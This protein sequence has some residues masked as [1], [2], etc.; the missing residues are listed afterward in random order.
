MRNEA[1]SKQPVYSQLAP[2]RSY[3]PSF[4]ILHQLFKHLAQQASNCMAGE[5]APQ[6]CLQKKN[7]AFPFQVLSNGLCYNSMLT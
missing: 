6:S 4:V 3:L 1:I 5:C 7:F 2:P